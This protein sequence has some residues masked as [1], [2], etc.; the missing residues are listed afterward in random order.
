MSAEGY[1][2]WKYTARPYLDKIRS[3]IEENLPEDARER[4]WRFSRYV[5]SDSDPD[6]FLKARKQFEADM[7]EVGTILSGNIHS[8]GKYGSE[9]TRSVPAGFGIY[10]YGGY[11]PDTVPFWHPG[12]P[13]EDKYEILALWTID[14]RLRRRRN[15]SDIKGPL[16]ATSTAASVIKFNNKKKFGKSELIGNC[17][18]VR[19][20]IGSHK[21]GEFSISMGQHHDTVY[22]DFSATYN[23]V[24]VKIDD[25]RDTFTI[26]GNEA[27]L[28]GQ[29]VP[30]S[31]I[32]SIIGRRL[33]EVIGLECLES[34]DT[35]ISSVRRK[36][37]N[38]ILGLKYGLPVL[39]D[40]DGT[41]Y[42][43]QV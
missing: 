15:A 14:Q 12:C 2:S 8:V 42:I 39:I 7:G 18:D 29:K 1:E 28:I 33:N 35:V 43:D 32:H 21:D 41:G 38:I 37:D 25:Y 30:E 10:T 6:W 36:D 23:L 20:N 4:K 9:N 22:S 11:R 19:M 3:I 34:D 13:V 16:Y 26:K 31:I 40:D 17:E 5:E 24:R 27:T